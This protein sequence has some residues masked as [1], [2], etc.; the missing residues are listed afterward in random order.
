MSAPVRWEMEMTVRLEDAR[1]RA[2]RA[3]C[4]VSAS[5][6]A[7]ISSSSSLGSAAIARAMD[8]SCHW[9]W[10]K[11]P[12]VQGVSYPCSRPL[13]ASSSPASRAAVRICS[14]RD[15]SVVEGDLVPD[16]TG[17]PVK[18]LLHAAEWLPPLRL[19]NFRNGNALQQYGSPPGGRKAQ[20]EV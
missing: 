5:R 1:R 17:H 15:G 9:P 10:E 6:L 7:V 16:S 11:M 8:N 2:C 18:A 4:S 19:R 3:A 13:M 14:S 20:A 12:G